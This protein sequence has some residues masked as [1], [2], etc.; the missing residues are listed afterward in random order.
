MLKKSF[1]LAAFGAAGILASQVEVEAANKLQVESRYDSGVKNE[2][3]GTTE[4]V[5]YNKHNASYYLVNGTSK[6]VEA[7]KLNDTT[8]PYLSIDVEKLIQEH[9]ADF[10]YGDLTSIAV[11][12]IHN[13][14]AVS[15]QAAGYNDAGLALLLQADGQLL[16]IVEVDA[17]PDNLVFTPDGK[18]LLVANEGEPREGY[19]ADVVDPN[20]T[21]S[22]I[23]VSNGFENLSAT[24]LTFTA[25]DTTEAR[26]QLIKDGVI[27]KQNTLPSA[28]LEPE[29]IAVDQNSRYAYVALQENNAIATIDLEKQEIISVK[30]MGFKDHAQAGNE[31]DVRKDG[32]I[33]IQNE[34]YK[35]IYM[36]DGMAVYT[37]N[38]KNYIVTANEGDAREWGDHLNEK[39]V[40]VDGNEIVFYDTAEYDGF[41]EG[42]EYIFGGRSFSIFDAD[43]LELVFDS[44]SDFEKITAKQFPEVFNT[45]N[46]NTKLDNRSG[47]KGPEPEDVKIGEVDGKVYAFIG[48]ERIGGIMMYDITNPVKSKFV[49]YIN[50]RDYSSDMGGDVSPEGM[51]FV[52]GNVPKLIV[53]HEVS[54]TVT[55][56][57]IQEKTEEQPSLSFEDTKNSWA[58]DAIQKVYKAGLMKGASAQRFNPETSVTRSQMAIILQRYTKEDAMTMVSYKDMSPNAPMTNAVSWAVNKG[59]LTATNDYIRPNKAINRAEFA[60]M[61]YQVLKEQKYDFTS[62][63]TSKFT[64]IADLSQAQQEAITALEKAKLM[65]GNGEKFNPK[66][67]ITR[68]QV[69]TVVAK[70]LQ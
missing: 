33:K 44:G 18:K 11:H 16:E 62:S 23:D 68:A 8:K 28:D 39:E 41:E 59:F 45:S 58:K 67:S 38:N 2:D 5:A 56:F 30:G 7:I 55:T 42:Q 27:L 17:Q 1:V 10:K 69:A 29:Y 46:T 20:G 31:L 6:K 43:T 24:P 53:G 19:G 49:D 64:D 61:M 51:A 3:G 50:T 66:G 32:E 63:T 26:Q 14:I 22:L 36:P 25:F 60:V 15:V 70:V 65:V 54:G 40:E 21:V 12:P 13:V 4:I 52:A 48:L 9:L 35:G 37:V 47:K 34:P 57:A